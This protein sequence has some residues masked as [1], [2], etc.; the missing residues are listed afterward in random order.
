[1]TSWWFVVARSCG[2][3][4]KYDFAA[5]KRIASFS[6]GNRASNERLFQIKN[7]Y[8]QLGL[9]YIRGEI[10]VEVTR[11]EPGSVRVHYI[12]TATY[13]PTITQTIP[14]VQVP[15]IFRVNNWTM[16]QT[17]VLFISQRE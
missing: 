12:V 5:K 8:N 6:I 13:D 10:S 3:L 4:H 15:V 17:S 7:S 2:T 16:Q 11:F 9:A 1:M 14:S